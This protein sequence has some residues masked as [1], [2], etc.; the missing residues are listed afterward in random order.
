MDLVEVFERCRQLGHHREG[1][2]QVHATDVVASERVDEAL[3]H[4]VSLRAAHGRVDRWQAPSPGHSTGVSRNVGA[5]V[6][7][8][9]LQ[10]VVGRD[11]FHSAEVPLHRVDQQLAHRLARQAMPSQARE[12][13]SSRSQQS[14]ANVAVIVWPR[15]HLIS[16]PSEH[17][18]RSLLSTATRPSCG[19]PVCC[20]R[21]ALGSSKRACTIT[22]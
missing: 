22:R 9:G 1:V 20:R 5:S 21:G 15:S 2:G 14:L 4:R 18:R 12:P 8:K 6:V 16:K 3:G 7:S 17:Q 19:R 13:T 10:L 11:R